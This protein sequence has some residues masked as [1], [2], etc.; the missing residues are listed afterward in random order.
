MK[1]PNCYCTRSVFHDTKCN[2]RM[3]LKATKAQWT[4]E[5][6][7]D[8]AEKPFNERTRKQRMSVSEKKTAPRMIQIKLIKKDNGEQRHVDENHETNKTKK[9]KKNK[10][11]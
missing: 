11:K 6:R 9:E 5:P 2:S 4:K 7:K 10:E 3:E 1:L 8:R